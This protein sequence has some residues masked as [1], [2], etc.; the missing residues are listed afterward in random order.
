MYYNVPHTIFSPHFFLKRETM[1]SDVVVQFGSH[2][3]YSEQIRLIFT[4]PGFSV[5][6]RKTAIIFVPS[7]SYNR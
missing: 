1:A 5:I 4:R 3:S 2:F 6:S 7:V